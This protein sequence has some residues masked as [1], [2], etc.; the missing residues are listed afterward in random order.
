MSLAKKT[1]KG[2]KTK[3]AK[4]IKKKKQLKKS[5]K[6]QASSRR[7][8][9]RRAKTVSKTP[10]IKKKK[11]K[12]TVKRKVK[13]QTKPK[14]KA[15]KKTKKIQTRSAK[16]PVKKKLRVSKAKPRSKKT[17]TL[18]RV[19][20]KPPTKKPSRVKAKERTEVKVERKRTKIEKVWVKYKKTG[21][22]ELK[23]KIILNY[24]PLVKYV[25]GQISARL[26]QVVD[27]A[28]LVSYGML[29]LMDAIEKFD[30]EKKVKFETYAVVRINGAIID[31]LR[32]LDWVPRPLR[33]KARRFE[34]AYIKLLNRLRRNPSDDEWAEEL[35]IS[36]VELRNIL[37]QLSHTSLLAL[38][39]LWGIGS[40]SQGE[41]IGLLDVLK[42]RHAE[43]PDR[44]L[45]SKETK[46]MM[47]EAVK[48][49]PDRE[50]NVITL[51]YYKGL[52]LKEIADILGLTE[53]RV[54]QLHTRALLR[55][56][57]NL[58]AKKSL[59]MA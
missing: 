15:K 47:I 9:T 38:D 55:L 33:Y 12:I 41:K 49:L 25:A 19:S 18:T 4:G 23:D 42:D 30:L 6:T 59:L 58:K 11:G 27:F 24:S 35:E 48:R 46:E 13:P 36:T 1:T 14:K 7:A 16:K 8:N 28:D 31:E 44:L 50:K 29:G 17:K 54:S 32:K 22:E 39:E 53:S 3:K 57:L 51:Y 2:R 20:K 40:E 21:S 37:D 10:R 52:A 34:E 45:D 26:P 5:K 43:E 56:K